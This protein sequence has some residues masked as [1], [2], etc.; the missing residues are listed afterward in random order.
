LV[1]KQSNEMTPEDRALFIY[2]QLTQYGKPNN[3]D[4]RAKILDFIMSEIRAAEELSACH[5][6]RCDAMAMELM[7]KASKHAKTEAYEDA[8]KI[9]DR[10]AESLG[11]NEIA[12]QIRARAKEIK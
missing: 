1:D 8:A 12:E 7:N 5:S 6:E 9:A 4:G 11:T 2:S 10:Y 3:S